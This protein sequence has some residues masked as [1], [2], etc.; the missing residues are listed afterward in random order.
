MYLDKNRARQITS[1]V[2]M[3]GLGV[4]FFTGDWWPGIMFLIGAAVIVQG[5]VE[6]RGWL[7]FQSGLWSI[8]IGVW[9]IYH[10]N[11]ALF[12]VVFGASMILLALIRP[13]AW[14]KPKSRYDNSL[15]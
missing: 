13:P 5:L 10:F 2:W 8:A 1:G 14:S 3:V 11:I 4:L 12:F 6:G 15:D 7:A 9:A